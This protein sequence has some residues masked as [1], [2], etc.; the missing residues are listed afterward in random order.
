[1]YGHFDRLRC[2]R[3]A[4]LRLEGGARGGLSWRV[5]DERPDEVR[6]V[7]DAADR[8]LSAAGLER[9]GWIAERRWRQKVL[10]TDLDGRRGGGRV[11]KGCVVRRGGVVDAVQG[12]G[13]RRG[14][15][16]RPRRA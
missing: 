16:P 15:G 1:G 3:R 6:S 14:A 2:R 13:D 7:R 10:R 5:G 12:D 9:R 11:G 4:A 8:E